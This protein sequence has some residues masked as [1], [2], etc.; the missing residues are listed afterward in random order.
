MEY[1]VTFIGQILKSLLVD[2]FKGILIWEIVLSI[3][4]KMFPRIHCF[5]L[6]HGDSKQLSVMPQT[7][8]CFVDLRDAK[9]TVN[10][11]IAFKIFLETFFK[12]LRINMIIFVH[13]MSSVNIIWPCHYLEKQYMEKAK[14]YQFIKI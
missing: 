9:S 6:T 7:Y 13:H 11:S 5:L 2:F 10:I 4:D 3:S 8:Y 1:W 14:N 12:D